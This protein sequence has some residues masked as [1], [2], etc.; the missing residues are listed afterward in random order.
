[1]RIRF[2]P[3][4]AMAR[5]GIW[6]VAAFARGKSVLST[7]LNVVADARVL[8]RVVVLIRLTRFGRQ[9]LLGET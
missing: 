5:A 7:G 3:R 2:R 9:R 1:M 6:G 8:L 4:D